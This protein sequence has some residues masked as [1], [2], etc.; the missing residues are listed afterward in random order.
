MKRTIHLLLCALGTIA[1]FFAFARPGLGWVQ[2]SQV[3]KGAVDAS[4]PAGVRD[5]QGQIH[6][7]WL[8]KENG[9]EE[10]FYAAGDGMTW[11]TPRNLSQS[12]ERTLAV[13]IGVNDR[14]QVAVLW[15][16]VVSLFGIDFGSELRAAVWQDGVWSPPQTLSS[17][18]TTLAVGPPA[19]AIRGSEIHAVWAADTGL[20]GYGDA[21]YRALWDGGA[22]TTPQPLPLQTGSLDTAA[23]AFDSQGRMHIV[24]DGNTSGDPSDLD[25]YQ[26]YYARQT[27]TGWTTPVN[28]SQTSTYSFLSALALDGDDRPHV[29]WMEE[30]TNLG[31]GIHV[32][33]RI[34]YQRW[35]GVAW[36]P[37]PRQLSYRS[38]VFFPQAA[39][40]AS[41]NV[42]LLWNN[43]TSENSGIY[44]FRLYH[45]RWDGERLGPAVR[46]LGTVTPDSA[47][48]GGDFVRGPGRLDPNPLALLWGG[49]DE[50]GIAQ[51]YYGEQPPGQI[52]QAE[53]ETNRAMAD[54]PDLAGRAADALHAVWAQG[55]GPSDIFYSQW[56]GIRWS[57]PYSISLPGFNS[58]WPAVAVGPDAAPHVAWYAHDAETSDRIYYTRQT[59]TGWLTP[60]LLSD[61]WDAAAGPDLAVDTGGDVHL[62]WEMTSDADRPGFA[63]Y[64]RRTADG[65]ARWLPWERISPVGHS[66]NRP[67]LALDSTG[68]PH[69]V[70]Y[71]VDEQEVYYSGRT[72]DGWSA[73]ENLSQSAAT[74]IGKTISSQGPSVAVSRDGTVYVAWL[75]SVSRQYLDSVGLAVGASGSWQKRL[76]MSR[77]EISRDMDRNAGINVQVVAGSQGDVHVV[78]FDAGENSE[79]HI[80]ES[81]NL[82]G[83]DW[84]L[85]TQI[86]E[87]AGNAIRPAAYVDA[88]GSLHLVWTEVRQTRQIF[89]QRQERFDWLKVA[90]SS[91]RPQPAALLYANG[92]SIGQTDSRGLFFPAPLAVGAELV[93]L[94][95]VSEYA[96][97][98]QRHTS[99]DAPERNW[100][101]R[102][103]L[104]N[105]RYDGAGN[106][107]G[108]AFAGSK[109]ETRLTVRGDAP[110]ALFNL[111]ASIEWDPEPAYT[112]T[113][114]RALAL[115]S[116]YLFD[117]SNGQ[118]AIGNVALYSGGAAWQDA[119]IQV[120]TYNQNRPNADINGLRELLSPA[121]RVGRSWSGIVGGNE[122]Q[123]AWDQPDGYRTLIHEF[124]HYALGLWDSYFRIERDENGHQKDRVTAHCT[125]KE[126]QSNAL[127]SVN[128]SLMDYQ[129]NASE[130]SMR[131]S[132]AWDESECTQTEQFA[133]HGESDWETIRRFFADTQNPPRW[134]WQTPAETGVLAGP[135]ALPLSNLPTIAVSPP[136]TP[137]QTTPLVV[138]GPGDSFRNAFVATYGQDRST[139]DQGMTD[140][141]GAI[142]LLG[143]RD[144]D[145]A[146]ALSWGGVYSGRT[147]LTAGVTNTLTLTRPQSLAGRAE[148]PLRYLRLAPYAGG[149]AVEVR[150]LGL[151]PGAGLDA[152]VAWIGRNLAVDQ[153]MGYTGATTGAYRA[154]LNPAFATPA[155]NLDGIAQVQVTGAAVDGEAVYAAGRVVFYSLQPGTGRYLASPD[156]R[157]RLSL[158]PDAAAETGSPVR[159]L[160]GEQNSFGLLAG[161]AFVSPVYEL[162]L[163]GAL[164]G[165]AAPVTLAI[166]ATAAQSRPGSAPVIATFD[167]SEQGWRLLP[168]TWDAENQAASTAVSS[169]GFY[170]LV[171][172]AEVAGEMRIYLPQIGN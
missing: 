96:G 121:V 2:R 164:P 102:V 100:A 52:S 83:A 104:T 59:A 107:L 103:Y 126:I 23:L 137:A 170:A 93:A 9:A 4:Q 61:E 89:Y 62:V 157:L 14:D 114:S 115:A 18:A 41:G 125:D 82:A 44:A 13:K 34:L 67:Q 74:A 8:Q 141:Q 153:V 27:E 70:W 112:E 24:W 20:D 167:E 57:T 117:A 54:S 87:D 48:S 139:M 55:T 146:R 53:V 111:V 50:Q 151:G 45:A 80:Y 63:I 124:G 81:N 49:G 101:Y 118:M 99:P 84:S 72:P 155:E 172:G 154:V 168:T 30:G 130:F 134:Q 163:G 66:A 123:G 78:W 105:W 73:A 26:I 161:M 39:T 69:V 150:F 36:L 110:L 79:L 149:E 145:E 42:H 56:N 143:V 51:I 38:G 92:T 135:S 95:P 148:Q 91:G 46:I 113:F 147:I 140:S 169:A 116:D 12:T 97:V 119:D 28:I 88:G 19:L 162:R 120:L 127:D 3:T 31:Q 40:D 17:I 152:Q 158:P 60:T 43:N 15:V 6:A 165:F 7:V 122:A 86:S 129:Y 77:P 35:D 10:A 144:G 68:A 32:F 47:Q 106:R 11:A 29:I 156:G 133:R 138:R 171:A 1:L 33:D 76:L 75:E 108:D 85:P 159:L 128:A 22:W 142:F 58:V 132:A 166:H 25:A 98:R 16:D 90:D 5:S 65:G 21:I 71:D 64:Y 136:I 109:G 131:N 37:Q 94:A 160:V